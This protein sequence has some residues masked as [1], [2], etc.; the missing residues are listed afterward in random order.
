MSNDYLKYFKPPVL[1]GLVA[2]LTTGLLAIKV[3]WGITLSIIGVITTVLSVVATNC[4]KSRLFNWMFWVD[5]ISGTYEGILRY[6]VVLDGKVKN[7]ELKHIK[8]INQNGY[9]ISVSSFTYKTDGTPSSPS[10]NIGMYIKKTTDDKHFELLFSYKNDGSREQ[11]FPP[12]YGTDF[13][14]VINTNGQKSITG[15]YYTEREPQTKGNYIEM[16]WVS[17]NQEH[18]F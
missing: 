2:A 12:H 18:K 6:Q 10:E 14:K 15:R 8:V 9:R 7:G 1:I 16:N 5:D 4:W 11:N 3:H 17:D 13:L